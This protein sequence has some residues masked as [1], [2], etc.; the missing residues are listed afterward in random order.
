VKKAAR[1]DVEFGNVL[2]LAVMVGKTQPLLDYIASKPLSD[3]DDRAMLS[4]YMHD[5]LK[6]IDELKPRKPGRPA[7]KPDKAQAVERAERNAAIL[8]RSK[9]AEWRRR[10]NRKRVPAAETDRL[11]QEIKREAARALKVPES[12]VSEDNIRRGLKSGRL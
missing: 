2:N 10:H 12:K 5:L 11:I 7:R 3:P 9:Q 4:R 8:V 6:R 1:A